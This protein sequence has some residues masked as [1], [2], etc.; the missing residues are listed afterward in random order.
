MPTALHS[1]CLTAA[2]F[3]VVFGVVFGDILTAKDYLACDG[4]T[5]TGTI[6]EVRFANC[7][8][9]PCKMKQ[10]SSAAL[11]IDFQIDA[12]VDAIDVS[13]FGV[14]SGVDIPFAGVDKNGCN[15]TT[16]AAGVGA[17]PMKDSTKVYTYKYE[18]KV[19][20]YPTIPVDIK[21]KL[22][23]ASKPDR[24]LVCLQIPAEIVS[25]DQ[26]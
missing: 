8:L 11:E 10:K 26:V 18:V 25:A 15:Y 1:L 3:G 22:D 6:K 24:N 2:I 4:V 21:F 20:N 5:S 16:D 19:K 13:T 17:C 23:D 9:V 7:P 14:I 12:P